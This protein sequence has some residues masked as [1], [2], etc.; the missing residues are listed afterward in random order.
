MK[1]ILIVTIILIITTIT[2][3]CTETSNT[4]ISNFE[5]L[6]NINNNSDT[7]SLPMDLSSAIKNGIIIPGEM[8]KSG[9]LNLCFTIDN[10][11]NKDKNYYYKIYYQNE[12]YKYPETNEDGTYNEKSAENFYG[13]W[14]ENNTIFKSTETIK[15]KSKITIYD[16][17]K[18][19]GNPR[20][21]H[22]YFGNETQNM[23]ASVKKIED[24]KKQINNSIEWSEG[25]KVKAKRNNVPYEEQL[26]MDAK[27]FVEHQQ[28]Q[29]SINNR[30]KRNPRVGVYSFLLVV[31]DENSQNEI[32][33]YISNIELKDTATRQFINPYFYYNDTKELPENIV[34]K[35]SK[36][37][38][39]A[40]AEMSIQNGIY[41]NPMDLPFEIDLTGTS[42]NLGFSDSLF[43]NAHFAQF[44]HN[45]NKNYALNNVP[46]PY[47][48]TGDNYTRDSYK[49]NKDKY[50]DAIRIK[51]FVK[52]SAKP[53]ETVGYNKEKEAIQIKNIGSDESGT[54][55]KENVGVQTRIGLTY[56]K[57]R[58]KI[59]FP[60]LISEDYVW[61]GLTCAFW[62]LYQE[63]DWN[64][65]DACYTGYIPK[66]L[67]G[68]DEGHYVKH[69]NYSEIDIEIVKTSKY[70]PKSSY[71][72]KDD[73]PREDAMNSNV[74]VACTNWDLA[75]QD[76]E[77]FT[78]GA[79]QITH[80]NQSFM[81]HRWD[82]W[83][84]A[85]TS[86]Y[87]NPQSQTLGKPFYFEIEWKPTEIIW[88]LGQSKNQMKVI[89][90]MN[91][92]TTKI[93]NNQ[94]IAVITQEFHDGSW[95]PTA[96][97]NQNNVPF[98]KSDIKGYV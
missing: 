73:Y 41:V 43:E 55:K 82:H 87:E 32:P 70:W 62:L 1:S 13:S 8:T 39:K 78:I 63:A 17:I 10:K 9:Y 53:G 27:W 26:Y 80:K 3:S 4:L 60:E 86:K 66:H 88:R 81:L 57:F 91:N 46:I 5:L 35:K 47:D 22:K 2:N 69:T 84:K 65:R 52:V 76:V 85:L 16:S 68:K 75:C 29:G 45:I 59:Q 12:T 40:S 97:F 15:T 37:Y 61:N 96:P 6:E 67:S 19:V 56:G 44:Y 23:T 83:Y 50:T 33:E 25:V 7:L 95:W 36:H 71:G 24:V 21:E 11:S 42:A 34:V 93:P 90:D 64:N 54:F 48:V 28:K 18:I 77:N 72:N 30:W 31:V 38:L 51:D 20:N 74:I 98:P 14:M 89:G 79:K 92:T 49:Q 58:A 94:M